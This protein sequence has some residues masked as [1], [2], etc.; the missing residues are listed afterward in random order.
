MCE[1]RVLR[2]IFRPKKD[3]VVV[4][5]RKLHSEELH[6]LNSSPSK[7]RMITSMRMKW[8]GM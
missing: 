5:C 3:E 2:R 6:N 4:V 7:I 1:N 8:A